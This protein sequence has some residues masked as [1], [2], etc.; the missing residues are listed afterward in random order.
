MPGFND[1]YRE[2][3]F[4]VALYTPTSLLHEER[5]SIKEAADYIREL[6]SKE[7]KHYLDL[8]KINKNKK[9]KENK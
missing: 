2:I 6:E 8:P 3:F 7:N 4:S 5:Q 9:K 1:K